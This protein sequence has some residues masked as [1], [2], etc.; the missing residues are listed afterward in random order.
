MFKLVTHMQ[1]VKYACLILLP[2][3][4]VAHEDF[5]NFLSLE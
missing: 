3:A 4:R 5:D 1:I 2:I